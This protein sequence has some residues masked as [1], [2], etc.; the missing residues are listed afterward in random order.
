LLIQSLDFSFVYNNG[1]EKHDYGKNQTK[2]KYMPWN[3][4][5]RNKFTYNQ[6]TERECP[7]VYKDFANIFYLFCSELHS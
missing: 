7:E 1:P 6:R 4:D 2:K 3:Y 5:S